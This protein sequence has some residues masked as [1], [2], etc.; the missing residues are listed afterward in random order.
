M[1][2]RGFIAGIC[3]GPFWSRA[4][5]AEVVGQMPLVGVLMAS[6]AANLT[7]LDGLREL[8][9]RLRE[10]GWSEDQ[11]LRLDVRWNLALNPAAATAAAKDLTRHDAKV[12]VTASTPVTQAARRATEVVPIV[13]ATGSDPVGSHLVASL[14]HP[15]GN[16][17][18]FSNFEFS[19]GAKWLELLKELQ[20]RINRVLVLASP[21]NDGNHGLLETLVN[22][23][24]RMSVAVST[25][26]KDDV[27]N[28]D[29]AFSAFGGKP[30]GGVIVLPNPRSDALAIILR[31]SAA[32][33]LPAIYPQSENAQAGG[34]MSYGVEMR[35]LYRATAGYVDRILRGEKPDDLPV[36]SPTKFELV[37]NM[38]T[39][40]AIGVVVPQ[41]LLVQA[42]QVIE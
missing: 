41:S 16:V 8:R 25:A 23:A 36:Q 6:D 30:D 32:Y 11:N 38:K 35:A 13:M 37:I 18:G 4:V 26:D 28:L 3:I 39:A 12:I 22:A 31:E 7:I 5:H 10:L 33:R 21:G 27:M 20:P 17:T 34:L 24:Q 15:G 19:I 40:K 29:T 14:R 1:R 42:D 9:A 2:R